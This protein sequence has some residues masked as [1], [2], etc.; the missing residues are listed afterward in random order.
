MN[1]MEG[2]EQEDVAVGYVVHGGSA[3]VVLFNSAVPQYMGRMYVK[4][5]KALDC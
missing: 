5:Q 1:S 3:P 2:A 4:F